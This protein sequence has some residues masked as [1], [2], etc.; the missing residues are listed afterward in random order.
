MGT[1]DGGSRKTSQAATG[2]SS[3]EVTVAWGSGGGSTGT[4]QYS[5]DGLDVGVREKRIK[6]VSQQVESN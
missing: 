4:W 3:Q 5:H 2:I 6:D 1:G